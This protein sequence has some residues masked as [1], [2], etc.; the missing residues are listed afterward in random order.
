MT[1]NKQPVYRAIWHHVPLAP[2][3]GPRAY[4]GYLRPVLFEVNQPS[5]WGT[6]SCPVGSVTYQMLV[7]LQ[8]IQPRSLSAA[9]KTNEP[10]AHWPSPLGHDIG[11]SNTACP[12]PT[13]TSPCPDPPL[14]NW[15]PPQGDGYHHVSNNTSQNPRNHP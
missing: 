7:T 3:P 9:L 12:K 2:I 5:P 4:T 1:S 14:L 15:S 10:T 13:L 8:S 6:S 11:P